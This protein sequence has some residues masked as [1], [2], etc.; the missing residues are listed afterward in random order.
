LNTIKKLLRYDLTSV[1][2]PLLVVFIA[3]ITTSDGFLSAYNITSLLQQI[4]IFILIGLAQMVVLSLGQFNL[5]LGSMG[6]LSAITMGY[7]MQQTNIFVAIILGLAMAGILGW[8]QGVLIARSGINP[9]IITL[10]LLSIYLG[11]ASVVTRGK[12]FV[13]LP[14]SIQTINSSMI[15]PVPITFIVS[16]IIAIIFFI[17]FKYFSIGKQLQAVGESPKAAL[18][19]GINVKR[20][21]SIGHAMSGFICGIA[22]LLQIVRFGSAQISIG[23]DWML[24]S[25]VV[26]VLGGTLL[27]GGKVSIV[28]T[29]LGS[30]LMMFINNIL[31]LWGVNT[32]MFQA[33]L[34]LV[35][36]GAFEMDRARISFMKRQGNLIAQQPK[37]E[38]KHE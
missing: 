13:D 31:L 30:F 28:G 23:D 4:A 33:I 16:I 22:G 9:F 11:I 25:F 37:E 29:V 5:A 7:F 1:V 3:L 15:G 21:T 26:A 19:S 35:L 10:S 36:L 34:G 14:A 27:S 17:I 2:L 6:C 24:T 8:I 38:S 12:P 20:V 32:Y 18:Y